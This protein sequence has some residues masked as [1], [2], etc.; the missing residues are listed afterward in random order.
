MKKVIF[1][2]AALAMAA[3]SFAG[4]K[5]APEKMKIDPKNSSLLWK[6]YKV[7]GSHEGAVSLKGGE[8]TFDGGK[9]VGGNFE[10]DMNSMTCTDLPADAAPKLLGHL[11][12]DDFF[13]VEKNPTA[14]FVITNSEPKGSGRYAVTGDLTIKGVKQEVK[15][16]AQADSKSATAKFKVDRTKFGIRYGSGSFFEN[17]GDKAISNEFDMTIKLATESVAPPAAAVS[18]S[19]TTNTVNGDNPVKKGK[20]S[21]KM[22]AAPAPNKN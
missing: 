16:D 19:T 22:K 7:T 17:L 12:T 3:F 18:T 8:L 9:L 5:P 1:M 6:G 15:F 10:I 13:G 2:F 14:S 20:K 4:N 21:K 11:K